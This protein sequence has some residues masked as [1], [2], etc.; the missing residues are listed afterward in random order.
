MRGVVDG[1]DV[2]YVFDKKGKLWKTGGLS[3]K[4]E[5]LSSQESQSKIQY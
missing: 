3:S 1:L 2:V 4:Q 5:F